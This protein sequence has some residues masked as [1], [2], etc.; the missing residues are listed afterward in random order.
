MLHLG[1]KR[2]L[3]TGATGLV[4]VHLCK[5]LDKRGIAY[6]RAPASSERD[7][8][9]RSNT[10]GLISAVRPEVVFHLAARVGGILDNKTR[11]ADFYFD[12]IRMSAYLFDA[13]ARYKVEKLVCLGTGCGYP[14]D[15]AEPLREEDYWQGLPQKES[16]AY[17]MAKKM[18]IVQAVAYRQQYGLRTAVLLPSNIYGP[19]DNFDLERAHAIPA[20]I[21]K[22]YEAKRNGNSTVQVWGNGRARR[23]F[24]HASDVARALVCVAESYERVEPLNISYG[25][26]HS[27]YDVVIKL[28]NISGFEGGVEWDKTKPEGQLS[29][30]FSLANQSLYLKQWAPAYGLMAGLTETYRWFADNYATARLDRGRRAV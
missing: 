28:K 11:P 22:F 26:Q 1:G 24:I 20:L 5:E 7:L 3:I 2:I 17:A 30:E 9:E 14:A 8:R 18:D 10:A 4:G 13:C 15:A 16:V 12:N 21:R 29:R 6:V 25:E 27:I 23:D 19:Y